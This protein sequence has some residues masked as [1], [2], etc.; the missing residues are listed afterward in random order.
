GPVTPLPATPEPLAE[1][2]RS[3]PSTAER[4][5]RAMHQLPGAGDWFVGFKLVAVLGRGAFGRVYLARQ[6][7]LADRFVALKV[8][9]DLSGE[10]R[11]L[12]RPH[13]PNIV[14]IYSVHRLPPFQAVCMPYFG[15]TTLAHLL[16]H[17]REVHSLPADGRQ[18]VDTLCVLNDQTG[19]STKT[20]GGTSRSN[21]GSDHRSGV[22]PGIDRDS[23]AE[24]LPPR[25]TP[26]GIFSF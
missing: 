2:G 13:H 21:G 3:D 24:P 22:R 19:A 5:R 23:T 15:A 6:G 20:L 17:Y 16:A 11:P 12:A 10:S 26:Q 1:L 18:L 7:E 4:L 8:S 25:D 14:P 9:T